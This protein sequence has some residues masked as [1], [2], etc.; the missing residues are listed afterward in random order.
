MEILIVVDFIKKFSEESEANMALKKIKGFF[1]TGNQ[2]NRYCIMLN[3]AGKF[4]ENNNGLALVDIESGSN[5][6]SIFN[7]LFKNLDYRISVCFRYGEKL[8]AMTNP[9]FEIILNAVN[10]Y[11]KSISK[12]IETVKILFPKSYSVENKDVLIK[13]LQLYIDKEKI[14]FI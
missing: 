3:S 5:H 8:E 9:P 11:L 13:E 12:K 10:D 6:Y 7:D 1:E 2:T 14:D 4:Y